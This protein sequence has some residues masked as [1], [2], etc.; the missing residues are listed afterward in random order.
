MALR[1][2]T[3]KKKRGVLTWNLTFVVQ[4]QLAN[5]SDASWNAASLLIIIL[6]SFNC[7]EKKIKIIRNELQYVSF[8]MK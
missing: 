4:R 7:F 2:L 6:L 3:Q 1:L 8:A 5:Y